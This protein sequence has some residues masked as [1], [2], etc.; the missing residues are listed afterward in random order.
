[1]AVRFAS[2]RVATALA[3]VAVLF[4][5]GFVAAG[6]YAAVDENVGAGFLSFLFLVAWLICSAL[7]VVALVLSRRSRQ[8]P[9]RGFDVT[10]PADRTG[11]GDDGR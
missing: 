2:S 9:P 5:G 11:P 8:N 3:G 7:A 6:L 1:M 4:F 10:F